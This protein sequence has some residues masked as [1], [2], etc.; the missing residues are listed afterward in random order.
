MKRRTVFFT[1]GKSRYW[2]RLYA[3]GSEMQQV[4][5]EK[6]DEKE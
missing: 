3:N 5:D 1:R 4:F 6:V 2:I